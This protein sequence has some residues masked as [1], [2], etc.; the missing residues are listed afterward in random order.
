[1]SAVRCPTLVGRRQ[2]LT[3]L[4]AS[5]AAARLGRGGASVL[6]GPAGIGKSRL[7]RETGATARTWNVPVLVGRAVEAGAGTA[8]RPLGEA[9]LAGLRHTPEPDDPALVPFRPALGRLIPQWRSPNAASDDSLVVLG[10]AVLRLLAALA[11]EHGL[12]LV[13]EDLHWADPETLAVLEYLADNLAEESVLLLATVRDDPGP[14]FGLLRTLA[15]RHAATLHRLLPLA[16]DEIDEM[17]TACAG[18]L[19]SEELRAVLRR[20]TGGI[21]LL[22]EELLA[23]GVDPALIVPATVAEL[24]AARMGVLPPDAR[25]C[26]E[27]AA[28]LGPNFDWQLLAAMVDAEIDVLAALRA[29]TGAGLVEVPDGGGFR[30]HHALGR[31]A[32][33]AALLPPERTEWARRGLAAVAAAHPKLEGGWCGVAADLALRAGDSGRA[34]AVLV[35]AGRRNLACGALASAEMVLGRARDLVGDGP[36]V[37]DVDEVLAEVLA[38][39][40][41]TGAAV[42]VITRSIERLRRT[43]GSERA[44]AQ[45]HLRLARVHATAGEWAAA[46]LRLEDARMH[47]ADSDLRLRITTVASQVALGDSRFADA[48]RLAGEALAGGDGAVAAD[49]TCDALMVLGRIARRDDLV[50]AEGRFTRAWTVAE[51]AGLVVAATRALEEP[52][53]GEVQESLRLDRLQE[54]RV[55][56]AGLGDVATVA[57]LDL[58][59]T[60]TLNARWEPE[61]ALEAANRCITASRRF[62]LVTLPKALVLGAVANDYLDRPEAAEAAM[63]EALL[64]APDDTHLL[65]EVWGVRAYRALTAADDATALAHLERAMASFALRPNEVTG[66]PAV[67]LWVLLSIVADPGMP[68]PPAPA[69]PVANRWNRGLVRFA[70]AVALGRAG[71][72]AAADAAFVD[73][74]AVLRGPTGAEWHRLQ[75]RRIVAGAALAERWGDPVRWAG[76]DLPLLEARGQDRWAAAVRGLLRRAGAVVPRRGR[77]DSEVPATLRTLGVTSRETDVLVLVAEGRANREIAERLFLSPR[78]VEK[79]VERLLAKTGTGRRTELVA[80]AAR[81]LGAR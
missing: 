40:G 65:G 2:Q 33:L 37:A 23:A 5:L 32:V 74:D 78:T 34:A 41:K 21:P 50:T 20:R 38:Q 1:M 56:A 62:R 12:L 6:V 13:L 22:V 57:V 46:D 68:T 35:E 26:V 42:A 59:A 15:D 66:S 44:L 77:G 30:F 31:D 64:L 58:Q 14:A 51:Q 75:G 7:A 81:I 71:D 47:T 79:H 52:A 11:G 3:A 27:A 29:A 45:A 73:A 18:G 72:G 10:E 67:G 19:A 36:L 70:D 54:A 60:A 53:I 24:V 16:D 9:L 61:P 69:D 55:R 39:A 28:V 8:F 48:G 17:A 25:H 63:A 76:E 43:P 80:Y 4:R 49:V